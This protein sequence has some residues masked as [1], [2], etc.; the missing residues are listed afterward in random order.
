M[1]LEAGRHVICEKPLAMTPAESK[2]SSSWPRSRPCAARF[3]ITCVSI[4]FVSRCAGRGS[5]PANSATS[6]TSPVRTSR[7]GCSTTPTSTGASSLRRAG[8][9]RAI[10]DIGTHW[11]D[12]MQFVVGRHI[13]EVFADLRTVLPTRYRPAGASET[14]RRSSRSPRPPSQ[15]RSIRKIT[16]RCS[17]T[18]K[19][20]PAASS[21]C[22]KLRRQEERHPPGNRR[23]EGLVLLGQR[24]AQRSLDRPPRTGQ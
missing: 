23:L 3:A 13:S 12:L 1:V 16:D 2:L 11:L 4:L 9:L 22:R 17:S 20:G 5:R 10:A 15:C 8:P 6:I 7:T 21:R 24:T 18:S 14:S 19:V